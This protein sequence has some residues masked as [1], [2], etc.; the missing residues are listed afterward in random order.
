M[1]F[2]LLPIILFTLFLITSCNKGD[3]EKPENVCTLTPEQAPEVRG[4]RLGMPYRDV[5]ERFHID[6][7]RDLNKYNQPGYLHRNVKHSIVIRNVEQL[8]SSSTKERE[9]HNLNGSDTGCF[10]YL[11]Q[12]VIGFNPT[13]FP[14]L[15]GIE[16][17][18]L[19]FD[20]RE[21]L[22]NI[23]A[24]YSSKTGKKLA[25]PELIDSLDLSKWTNWYFENEQKDGALSFDSQE[26]LGTLLC[27]GLVIEANITYGGWRGS[28]TY[29]VSLGIASMP[30][31]E[32]LS[33]RKAIAQKEEQKEQ[34]EQKQQ[35]ER[36]QQEVQRKKGMEE[37]NRKREPFKP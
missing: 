19:S 6:C 21:L 32:M 20:E 2:K 13:K 24:V 27:N 17:L 29:V 25:L 1:H 23:D 34:K 15:E 30:D 28:D 12:N 26:S 16:F 35:D 18:R 33:I 5:V 11:L 9:K 7:P 31:D 3:V 14:E 37:E 36:K 22:V 10:S 4:F 8:N